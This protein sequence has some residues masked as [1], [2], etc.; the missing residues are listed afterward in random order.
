LHDT[1]AIAIIAIMSK[2]FFIGYKIS[3][4]IMNNTK[5]CKF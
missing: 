4:L 1:K 2:S 3:D 5:I